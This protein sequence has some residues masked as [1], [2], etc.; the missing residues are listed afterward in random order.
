MII[1][2]PELVS[3]V[4]DWSSL[5]S[6]L[7]AGADSLYF[8]V[9]GLN[10]RNL[11]R[12]FDPSEI[13][14]VMTIL[15]E[16]GKK[17]YLALN[18]IIYDKEVNKIKQILRE[19]KKVGV[20]A[21]ILWDLAVFT[22]AKE[23]GLRIHLS[24]QASVAN[25]LA[26]KYYYQQ[27]I[28]RVI[29]A[30]E[31]S[32]SDIKNII[33]NLKKNHINCEVETFI[34]G[35]MCISISG[36][37]LLSQYSF[38]KS[39]NRG[40]CLQPCRREFTI[41]DADNSQYLI[42]KDYL[43]SSKDLCTIDFIDPLIKA[44]ISA[45][46][47]EGR[48]RSSEYIGITTSVYRRAIDYFFNGKLDNVLKKELKEELTAVYNRG[49]C[50]GFY[51]DTPKDF[52]SRSLENNYEKIFI[53]QVKKFYKKIKVAEIKVLNESLRKN[54]QILFVGKTTPASFARVCDIQVNHEFVDILLKGQTGGVKIPFLVRSNDKVFLWQKK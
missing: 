34:H 35:A 38:G 27:G 28:K 2:K 37:C 53:G 24:T 48:I 39:A 12:N 10:M 23:M 32:L 25:F 50:S 22:I 19:A 49:F 47:I 21:V 17:G 43:L 44:G 14:K 13:K 5:Y 33:T 40:E 31:C 18:V 9:K 52:L 41:T 3:P 15:H 54:S 51:W 7:E 42:G 16:R 4:G 30:R 45:F 6:A 1:K 26:L 8:G 36:R 29:L 20:D 11:A 46:K